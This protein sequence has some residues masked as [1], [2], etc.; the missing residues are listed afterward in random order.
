MGREKPNKSRS[1]RGY[2]EIEGQIK[3]GN[4]K[5]T[6]PEQP[7]ALESAIEVLLQKYL[8]HD[9]AASAAHE[10]G[11]LLDS[12]CSRSLRNLEDS[13]ATAWMFTGIVRRKLENK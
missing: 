11:D 1:V 5:M 13:L 10:I 8:T 3:K 2:T 7:K 6:T 4:K 9:L 12:E